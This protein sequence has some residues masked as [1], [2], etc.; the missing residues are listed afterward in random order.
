[1][2][3]QVA[4][5]EPRHLGIERRH[6]LVELLDERHLETQVREVL[7]HLEADEPAADHDRPLGL[8]D[9]L[10]PRVGVH[11]GLALLAA[12][13]PLADGPG[14]GDGPDGEDA[15]QVN[16]GKRRTDRGRSGRQHQLV[17]GFG[18]H[19]ACRD[20]AQFD[21]LLRRVDGDRLAPRPRVDVE[22]GPEHLLRGDEE[23][24]LLRD[25]A[26]DVVRQPA[27]R[28]RDVRP[29]FHHEDF[30]LL[31]QPAQARRARRPARHSAH[32]DDFHTSHPLP[33]GVQPPMMVPPGLRRRSTSSRPSTD[34]TCSKRISGRAPDSS[35]AAITRRYAS[36]RR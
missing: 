21:G 22:H 7:H 24:R 19:V 18:R 28:V 35:T 20:I 14:I 30:G 12:V 3:H 6:D 15:R 32:D 29:A 1:M 10:E 4:L 8:R 27:V 23:A 31:V 25:D 17:V 26:A 16:P 5:D 33:R 9:G 34:W 11:P 36:D 2:L 13:Q